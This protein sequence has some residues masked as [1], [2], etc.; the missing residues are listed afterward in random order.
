MLHG[1]LAFNGSSIAALNQAIRTAKYPGPDKAL[2]KEAHALIK[3]LLVVSVA[4]RLTAERT[5]DLHCAW[6]GC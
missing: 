2:S 4:K 6:L 5:S 1:H 3:A